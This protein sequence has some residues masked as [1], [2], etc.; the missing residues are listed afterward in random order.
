M[1]IASEIVGPPPSISM[2]GSQSTAAK[3]ASS[4]RTDSMRVRKSGNSVYRRPPNS[5]SVTPCLSGQTPVSID[6]HEG[7]ETDG[8]VVRVRAVNDPPMANASMLGVGTSARTSGR[9]PSMPIRRTFGVRSSSGI[10]GGGSSAP[11]SHAVSA[12]LRNASTIGCQTE[13]VTLHF[14]FHIIR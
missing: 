8:V 12:A 1:S 11:L 13:R 5:L 9:T 4:G 6:D 2:R 14:R 7:P 3:V 10:I